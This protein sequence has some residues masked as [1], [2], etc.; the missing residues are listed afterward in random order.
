M[1]LDINIW[2]LKNS[3]PAF[4]LLNLCYKVLNR[5]KEKKELEGNT[6]Q[7]EDISNSRLTA[8][9]ERETI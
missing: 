7:Q 8:K 2:S 6:E 3:P 5:K 9:P 4:I 1:H